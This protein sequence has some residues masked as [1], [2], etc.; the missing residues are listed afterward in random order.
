MYIL[1]VL[2][3][4]LL[5]GLFNVFRKLSTNKSN[6]LSILVLFTT[7]TFILT[8]LT[9]P[10]GISIPL[11]LIILFMIKGLLLTISWYIVFKVL[12]K[13]D[14]SLVTV[15][16]ITSSLLSF[17][18]GI[19]L[20][21]ETVTILQVIGAMIVIFSIAAFNHI[22]KSNTNKV[23]M[24]HFLLLSISALV[25]TTCNVMDKYTTSI[26]EPH[27]IQF[28]VLLFV[29][30]FSWIFFFIE[31]L[32]EKRILLKKSDLK[33]HPIYLASILLFL[34]DNILFRAY[35]MPGSKMTTITVLSQLQLIVSIFIGIL[36]FKEKNVKK[37]I[38]LTLLVTLG[39]IF[40]CI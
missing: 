35:K 1:F 18:L 20:F 8:C 34:G 24:T 26:L 33:N 14:L 3:S 37:K 12:S 32:K 15:T 21:N 19:I 17:I 4:A 38:F 9:I 5:I 13:A 25:T 40:I 10:L 22:D 23:K 7:F 36:I 11:E 30:L 2:I 31:C 6:Q 16:N 27:Q 28:W 29:S 39:V